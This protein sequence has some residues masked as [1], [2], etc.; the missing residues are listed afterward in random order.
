M[1]HHLKTNHDTDQRDS[2]NEEQ[3]T[4]VIFIEEF[5]LDTQL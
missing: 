3:F 4:K 2:K 1:I 5:H